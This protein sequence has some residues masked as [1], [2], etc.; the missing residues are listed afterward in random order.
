MITTLGGFFP[1]VWDFSEEVDVFLT[2]F[3]D[4]SSDVVPVRLKVWGEEVAVLSLCDL[5]GYNVNNV[6]LVQLSALVRAF[7]HVKEISHNDF[8][9]MT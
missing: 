7:V 8:L 6:E 3:I 4:G 2:C 1:L 5:W 9:D